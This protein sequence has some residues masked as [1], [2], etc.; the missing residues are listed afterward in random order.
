M[1]RHSYESSLIK[2]QSLEPV[3]YLMSRM[4][5]EEKLY[6]S[7]LIPIYYT[8]LILVGSSVTSWHTH[9]NTASWQWMP[10]CA[11]H[12]IV[13]VAWQLLTGTIYWRVGSTKHQMK[14]LSTTLIQEKGN[15]VE[16]K[17][18][19][20]GALKRNRKGGVACF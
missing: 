7:P 1:K 6:L 8:S 11:S 20:F 17:N 19:L 3:N 2:N 15:W 18:Y 5:A 9:Y 12:P 4:G 16:S 14:A 10:M 13:T